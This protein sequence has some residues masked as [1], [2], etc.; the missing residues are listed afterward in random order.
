MDSKIALKTVNEL[1][2]ENFFIPSF[3]R[4]YRWTSEEVKDLLDDLLEF[5]GKEKKQRGI[6]LPAAYCRYSHRF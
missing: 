3:Q 4:G 5:H 2:N 6:L 1:L